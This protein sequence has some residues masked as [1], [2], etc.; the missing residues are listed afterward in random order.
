MIR[1]IFKGVWAARWEAKASPAKAGGRERE[2]KSKR[3][4][5]GNWQRRKLDKKHEGARVEKAKDHGKDRIR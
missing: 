4:L 5:E 2:K 3:P 1:V